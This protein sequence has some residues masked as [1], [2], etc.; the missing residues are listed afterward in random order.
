MDSGYAIYKTLFNQAYPFSCDLVELA[1]YYAAYDRMMRHWHQVLPGAIL[2]VRYEDLVADP[3]GQARRLLAHCGLPWD[4]AVLDAA[5]DAKPSTTASAA[6]VR[7]PIH[8]R[9][10]SKW[11]LHAAGLEPLRARLAEL[12]VLPGQ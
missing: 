12:G 7:E 6:Q 2:D 11:R 1:D 5:S 10:V 8:S 4:D 9:S 3:E